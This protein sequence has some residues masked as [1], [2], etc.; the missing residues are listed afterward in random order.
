MSNIKRGE[1][2]WGFHN[3]ILKRIIK[4]TS[5]K[6]QKIVPYIFVYKKV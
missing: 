2:R 3:D 4:F 1:N 6:R 5:P